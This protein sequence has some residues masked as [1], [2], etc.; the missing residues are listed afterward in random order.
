MPIPLKTPSVC[1][2]AARYRL[3]VVATQMSDPQLCHR[4]APPPPFPPPA[5]TTPEQEGSSDWQPLQKALTDSITE[6][7]MQ[8]KRDKMNER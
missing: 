2:D 6:V 1:A 7:M 4:Y 8:Q 3:A 5:C